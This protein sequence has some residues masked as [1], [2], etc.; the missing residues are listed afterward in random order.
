MRKWGLVITLFYGS[1]VLILL[2]PGFLLLLGDFSGLTGFYDHLKEDYAAWGTW[3]VVGIL[4]ASEALLLFLRVD[5]SFRRLKPR[6]HVLVSSTITAF[7][8]VLLTIAGVYSL[9]VSPK[10]D[11]AIDF[12]GRFLRGGASVAGAGLF[13]WLFW[14]VLFY[15]FSRNSSE[16][17]TRGVTWMLRGSVLELLIAVPAHVLVRRRHDCSAPIVTSFGITSGIAI[18]L[19]SFGPSVL[20]LYQKRMEAYS[21]RAAVEKS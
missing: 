17:V 20:L 18:M 19:L 7:F 21:A 14:G 8:L 5:T 15:L 11:A 16:I 6:A 13:L 1:I 2:L 12:L 9:A 4:L 10:G 3:I